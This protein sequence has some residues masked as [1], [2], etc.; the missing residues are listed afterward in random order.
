MKNLDQIVCDYPALTA[1]G[2]D[3]LWR[4]GFNKSRAELAKSTKMFDRAVE[5]L[6]TIPR[7]KSPNY[8]EGN[9]YVLKQHA[10]KEKGYISNGAMIAAA[11]ALGFTIQYVGPDS[12]NVYIS[13]AS[14]KKWINSK[15]KC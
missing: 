13:V 12:P 15:N 8:V 2:F 9:S 1:L 7:R 10:S 6:E 5:W 4:N 3:N 11:L 14:R